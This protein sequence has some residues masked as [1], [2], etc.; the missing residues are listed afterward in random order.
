MFALRAYD[1][2]PSDSNNYHAHQ[3]RICSTPFLH[4]SSKHAAHMVDHNYND[5]VGNSAL[6]PTIKRRCCVPSVGRRE[7]RRGIYYIF[8][9]HI[10]CD[11]CATRASH[12]FRSRSRT[13]ASSLIGW[14]Y[15]LSAWPT[16]GS[17][18]RRRR[19]TAST[20]PPSASRGDGRE[21]ARA[22][23]CACVQPMLFAAQTDV[24]RVLSCAHC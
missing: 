11:R 4:G 5:V 20:S 6:R 10:L 24:V 3:L 19:V 2:W 21:R 16:L 18:S 1:V 8:M 12:V 13:S 14:D 23:A 17:P 9:T 22:R 15:V 7:S